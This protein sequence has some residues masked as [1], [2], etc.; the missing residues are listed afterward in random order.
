MPAKTGTGALGG[1]ALTLASSPRFALRAS[2]HVA[3]RNT[4]A[5]TLGATM[6]LRPW[7]ADVD[8]VFAL[9]GRPLGSRNRT[10]ASYGFVGMGKSAMD[11]ANV[12][13]TTKNW[14]YGV[15][16]MVPLAASVDLFAE[17]RWRMSRFVLPTARPKPTRSKE[18]RFGMSFHLAQG[19]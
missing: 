9:V 2:G 17:W 18:I 10:A 3:L 1:L 16:S 8:A 4:S 19:D 12:R 14:S 6:W 13:A 5:S 11:T 15:G 7:T